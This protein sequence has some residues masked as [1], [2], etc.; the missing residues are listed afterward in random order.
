MK[1]AVDA[2]GGD[3]APQSIVEGAVLAAREHG[4]PIA[5]VGE[6]KTIRREA[7][8]YPGSD[9]LPLTFV[10]ASEVVGMDESPLTPI[11]KKKDSSIKVAFDLLKKGEVSAVVSAGNSGAVLA[12]AVFVLD[13]LPGVDRPAIG[14]IFPTLKGWTLLLDA[15][16]N[17]D[18]KS[19][20]LVQFAIMGEAY[21]KYIL[22][23]ERPAVGLLSNGEEESKGNE[24]IRETNAIL[25]KSSIGYIG[26]VE[27]RDIFSGRA[28]VV[29]CDGFVGNAA[30]K[31]CEG[32]AEAIG[33]MIRQEMQA[34][35]RAKIGYFFARHA[36]NDVKK[37]MDYSEYGGAP[38]LGV[39]GVVIIGHGRSSAKATKNAIRLAHDF[40]QIGLPKLLVRN[41]EENQDLQRLGGKNLAK[42]WEQIKEK[43]IN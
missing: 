24:L 41:L 18:C 19:F 38:L 3:F 37:K 15:G 28:D 1:I 2:M 22:K 10:H 17:V 25:R 26:P 14:T 5:L 9:S 40:A 6:E 4:I 31:I 34:S 8:K 43:I 42:V 12:T 7:A 29:I 35:L 27:G 21:A 16:A 11:R 20:H 23:Q 32:L 33:A 39:D 13:K 36:I 30:L